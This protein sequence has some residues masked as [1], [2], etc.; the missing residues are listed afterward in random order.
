MTVNAVPKVS[1][2]VPV[3]NMARYLP[4]C[5]D[6]LLAQT[7]G[8]IEI[9]AVND[10]S[11]D[12]SLAIL[13]DYAG[14]DRMMRI[15][16]KRNS[17]YG[18][19]LNKALEVAKGEYVGIVEPDDFP[20]VT[21]FS[22]LYRAAKRYD[23]DVVKCNYFEH[24]EGRDTPNWNLD[25]FAYNKPFDPADTPAIICTAPTIWT[26]L[27]RRE[28]LQREGI[29]FRTTPGASFQDAGF[30]LKVWFAARSA[31]LVRRPLLHYRVDN[32]GSSSK[33]TDKV[34]TVCDE[35]ESARAFLE[36]QPAIRRAAFARWIAVDKW[37]KYRWN[38]ERI[39]PELHEEFANRMLEEYRA[40]QQ[41]G[42]LDLSL[43]DETSRAQLS[44]LLEGG[45][46]AFAAHYPERYEADW[47]VALAADPSQRVRG[48]IKKLLGRGD[49]KAG[50]QSETTSAS[51]K[52]DGE[53]AL[54]RSDSP[55][56]VGSATGASESLRNSLGE[57]SLA[58]QPDVQ[59]VS[60]VASAAGDSSATLNPDVLAV[61]VIVPV[62]NCAKYVGECIASLKGQTFS[63][64]EAIVI[65]DGS[66]DESLSAAQDAVAGDARFTVLSHGKNRGLSAA[67]NTGLD[68][69]TGEY[70]VFLDSDD[71]LSH[72]ALEKLVGRARS[73]R[74]DDLY[75]SAVS[76]YDGA[77]ARDVLR[78][79]FSNRPSFEGVASGRDLFVFFQEQGQFHTQAALRMVKRQLLEDRGIR[80]M[81]GILHE[82]ILFTF[83][84]LNASA[85]SSFLNEPL[86][87]RR[88]REGSIMGRAKWDI[89]N[90][91][92][93]FVS[94][95]AIRR[96]L[97][98]NIDEM[99]GDY[100][101]AQVR[102]L[103]IWREVC[104]H[105]W[106]NDFTNAQREA[107]LKTLSAQD[108]VDFYDGIVG[109]GGE[110]DRVRSEYEES[111]TYRV[112][113]VLVA[114]PRKVRDVL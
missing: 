19:S 24:R 49:G 9:I 16:D 20:G 27:Y 111:V 95:Q 65:D 91:R 38:Y 52:T 76:F 10:G 62:Y 53:A 56:L 68:R 32:P 72:D 7:L 86:Y 85:R 103:G 67:R 82:D 3:Y 109:A 58:A 88:M 84:T 102:Q 45:A 59:R 101:T 63:Q 73:Q 30:A 78:E 4:Q 14:R 6:A 12:V 21:M 47:E 97:V 114:G 43:F 36:R 77:G 94:I 61:T 75:F 42:E 41:A 15:I 54:S 87:R 17:G 104:A 8:E 35:L 23:V 40:A 80:F 48:F 81:E 79:D 22:R 107:Y 66:V 39:A 90:I 64:F 106:A 89:E 112:G 105:H 13:Q 74:L 31:V 1:V 110:A 18:D 60:K 26:G 11:T 57:G 29:D 37:G 34:Y 69:A 51:G 28:F 55:R 2:L 96:Y 93:H 5:L 71:Y 100:L 99:S 70:V 25:G 92:G 83:L 113:N 50:Q 98:E 44:E 108:L 33:S 46:E